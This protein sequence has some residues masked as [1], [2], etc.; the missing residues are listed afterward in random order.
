MK[1]AEA[2]AVI[3]EYLECDYAL[4]G[5]A[6]RSETS[7]PGLWCQEERRHAAFEKAADAWAVIQAALTGIAGD[8]IV[9][10]NPEP[11]RMEV[12]R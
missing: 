6:A 8:A 12:E 4:P 2:V 1:V 3:N 9:I 11:L 5:S 7:F 10:W